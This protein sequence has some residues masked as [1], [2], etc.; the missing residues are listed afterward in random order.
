MLSEACLHSNSVLISMNF[1]YWTMKQH[2][3]QILSGPEALNFPETLLPEILRIARNWE[4]GQKGREASWRAWHHGLRLPHRTGIYCGTLL[5]VECT[6]A[7]QGCLHGVRRRIKEGGCVTASRSSVVTLLQ[8][9][10]CL[11]QAR[12]PAT[13]YRL[14]QQHSPHD[15][16]GWERGQQRTDS[17]I[18]FITCSVVCHGK[19]HRT[20]GFGYVPRPEKGFTVAIYNLEPARPIET[21]DGSEVW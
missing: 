10:R 15:A 16:T 2:A 13:R 17:N 3:A 20:F 11:A 14:L 18:V 12:W 6:N 21:V 5:H 7:L 9:C 8:H 1:C 19:R 4:P